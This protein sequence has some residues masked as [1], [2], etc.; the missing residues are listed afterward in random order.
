MLI[1]IPKGKTDQNWYG[2]WIAIGATHTPYCPVR[3]VQALLTMG[4]YVTSHLSDDCGPLLRQV[5]WVRASQ[6]HVLKQITAPLSCPIPPL[7]ATTL[8]DSFKMLT[9]AAAID[10][11]LN[12]HSGRIG[13]VT[14]CAIIPEIEPRLVLQQ[15]RWKA[16]NTMDNTYSRI[17]EVESKKFFAITRQ[18]W[19]H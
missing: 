10:K 16:Q 3:L 12:L 7:S 13:F 9:L 4:Q 17:S 15:G 5:A 6:S 18:I 1:F 14:T 8:R 2:N 11:T 19:K